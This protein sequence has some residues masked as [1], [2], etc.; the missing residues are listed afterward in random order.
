[1]FPDSGLLDRTKDLC[2]RRLV[3][4]KVGIRKRE[5]TKKNDAEND[6]ENFALHSRLWIVPQEQRRSPAEI[7]RLLKRRSQR[8]KRRRSRSGCF[9]TCSLVPIELEQTD[10]KEKDGYAHK[11]MTVRFNR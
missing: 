6:N 11:P 3:T 5:Q 4:V 10:G 7:M 1:M 9:S 2:G 8:L